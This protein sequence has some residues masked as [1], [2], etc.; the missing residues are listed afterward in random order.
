MGLMG[1]WNTGNLC[2]QRIEAVLNVLVASVY[3]FDIADK[4]GAIGT[5]GGYQQGDTSTN[6]RTRHPAAMQLALAVVTN[7]NGTVWVAENNLCPHVYQ[8]VNEEQAA[9]K[10]LLVE[11]H[12]TT[13][14]RSYHDKH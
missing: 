11:Q 12:R 10:H 14:L 8:A 7:N 9:L 3:L 5:H 1:L 6:I 13:G 4:A 2:S